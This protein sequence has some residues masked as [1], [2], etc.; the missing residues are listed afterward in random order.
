MIKGYVTL[1][2]VLTGSTGFK[3]I[4]AVNETECL[5]PECSNK[6]LFAASATAA[7]W[8][9]LCEK[10]ANMLNSEQFEIRSLNENW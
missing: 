2:A 3:L 6:S 4:D 10:H 9:C 7:S 5:M 8:L 1:Q